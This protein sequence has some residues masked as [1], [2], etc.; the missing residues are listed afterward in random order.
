MVR[1]H[2]PLETP[3]WNDVT[4]QQQAAILSGIYVEFDFV[5]EY[6]ETW[7]LRP[8]DFYRALIDKTI[9]RDAKKHFREGKAKYSS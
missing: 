7:E 2:I 4:P 5:Y 6:M 3:S 8:T 9:V 1:E